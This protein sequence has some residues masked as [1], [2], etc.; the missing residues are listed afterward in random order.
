MNAA[1]E[2][3][4]RV[5]TFAVLL[6]HNGL[7]LLRHGLLTAY[8]IVV[9]VYVAIIAVL[10]ESLAHILAPVFVYTD[11]SMVGLLFSGVIALLEEQW[12][13][14]LQFRVSGVSKR[15]RYIAWVVAFLAASIVAAGGIAVGYALIHRSV[16]AVA[17]APLAIALATASVPCTLVGVVIAARAHSPNHFFVLLI[18]PFIVFALPFL[19][20]M[21]QLASPLWY[22]VPG[23]GP[24]TL[25]VESVA[26]DLF[27][28]AASAVH[29]HR[30]WMIANA[31]SW[32]AL[33]ILLFLRWKPGR[34]Q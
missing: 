7:I 4:D 13:V 9:L 12:G 25:T 11:P 34:I 17:W 16:L 32:C 21:P 23:W 29:P 2:R 22:A 27:P 10:P 8:G 33:S 15:E 30:V 18:P 24:L 26:G 14:P 3:H 28:E 20:L 6:Q 1:G 31:V 5:G 19:S